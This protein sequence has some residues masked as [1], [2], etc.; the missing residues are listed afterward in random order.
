MILTDIDLHVE[1]ARGNIV[2]TPLA[3][4]AIGTNSINVHLSRHLCIYEPEN[5]VIDAAKPCNVRHFDIPEEGF[6]LLPGVLYL[7]ST[8]EYTETHKHVPILHGTS[9]VGRLGINVHATAGFG[10]LGFCG[11]WTLEIFVIQPVK[12]YAGMVVGQ[13]EYQEPKSLPETKYMDR[14]TSTYTDKPD[15]KPQPSRLWKKLTRS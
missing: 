2:V 7:A 10:D 14:E 9:S 13:L 4:G 8:L 11:Y 12:V 5:H 6:V 15:P 1:I 3:E